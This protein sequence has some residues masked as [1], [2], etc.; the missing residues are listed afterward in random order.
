MEF[1]KKTKENTPTGTDILITKQIE[2]ALATLP[3][4]KDKKIH[5]FE[6][7]TEAYGKALAEKI[8]A[9]LPKDFFTE[10][11]ELVRV[12]PV[13][14]GPEVGTAPTL[15]LTSVE[16]N[17]TLKTETDYFKQEM[18]KVYARVE[19][20]PE[21]EREQ[22]LK[23]ILKK[24]Y[25]VSISKE[26]V[27]QMEKSMGK[28]FKWFMRGGQALAL[29]AATYLI[30]K[31][32]RAKRG[33]RDEPVSTHQETPAKIPTV[34]NIKTKIIKIPEHIEIAPVKT[35]KRLNEKVLETLPAEGREVYRYFALN[36]PTPG[37]GY[38]ILD[39]DN[40][41]EYIFDGNNALMTVLTP[42]FGK[43]AGD[44]MNTSEGYNTG[45]MTTPAGI[46]LI[47]NAT[48]EAD[49]KEY[50]KLQFSLFGVSVLGNNEFLKEHQTYTGHGEFEPRTKK[51]LSPTPA[52]NNFSN[53]CVNI[54]SV[55]FKKHILPYFQGD[56]G[57]LLFVLQDKKGRDSGVKFN[58]DKLVEQIAPAIIEMANKEEARYSKRIAETK[59]IT[60]RLIEEMSRL[61]KKH[62]ELNQQYQKNKKNS[63]ADR[64]I[65][66]IKKELNDK[67]DAL[68]KI[69]ELLTNADKK[70]HE[71][72]TKREAVKRILEKAA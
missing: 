23:E 11:K 26:K 25:G 53:G 6:S 1:W 36:D 51:L 59:P 9:G 24:E 31:D 21:V 62:I 10:E 43:E 65:A 71:A 60:H 2:N 28:G 57:E 52:D 33:E 69:R 54:D 61:Q 42:G 20:F 7:L 22:K 30:H 58:T 16:E 35:N 66:K 63:T 8:V 47:S 41:K 34:E 67:K 38:M 5:V 64:E 55:D 39:K 37:R 18:E 32:D 46:Y 70:I 27:D 19:T 44:S 48:L 13:T 4:G 45:R 40:A 15:S 49:I 14:T 50:G 29:L 68:G 56:Y 12:T 72:A 3:A 17:I